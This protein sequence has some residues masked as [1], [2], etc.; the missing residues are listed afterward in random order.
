MDLARARERAKARKK[1]LEAQ[2]P[3][4][5]PVSSPTPPEPPVKG[6]TPEEALIPVLA[7]EK[8]SAPE[9]AGEPTTAE[10]QV[11]VENP[12]LSATPPSPAESEEAEP[13][14]AHELLGFT[15]GREEYGI[16]IQWIEEIIKPRSVTEVPRSP[17]YIPG[18]ISL[19]GKIVPIMELERRLRLTPVAGASP[20]T[21]GT[22][23]ETG[24]IIVV[25]DP[26][27]KQSFGL[28]VGEVTEVI[29]LPFKELEPP[30]PTA[31]GEVGFITG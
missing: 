8:T 6:R 16:E 13:E 7:P 9:R 28:K 4:P 1:N 23:P 11:I 19:R 17:D 10:T 22:A 25:S 24:R 15:L 12:A 30:P 3:A 20:A 31:G 29:R 2:A 5:I 27:S 18:I 14:E 26:E 21:G